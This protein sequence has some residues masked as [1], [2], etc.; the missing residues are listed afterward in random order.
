MSKKSLA[1]AVATIAV[2]LGS[3]PGATAGI[4]ESKHSR[5]CRSLPVIKNLTG[6]NAQ[7][8]C[9]G[10]VAPKELTRAE[11]N[12][13]AA[14][15]KLPEDHLTVARFYRAEASGL[16][17]RASV[18]EQAATDLR[19]APVAKNLASPTAAGQFEFAAAGFREQAKADRGLAASHEEMAK[20]VVAA[21]D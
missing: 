14:T 19:N 11:V 7:Q 9:E 2:F 6:L 17:A 18:Y 12:K 5:N 3:V 21:L 16:D 20:T 10:M 15:A 13:L 4:I 8:V 1:G